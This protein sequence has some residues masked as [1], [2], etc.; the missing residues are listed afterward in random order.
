VYGVGGEFLL[1]VKVDGVTYPVGEGRLAHLRIHE[2]SSVV[3]PMAEVA[4]N[5]R[6]N[7]LVEIQG[8]TGTEVFEIG[9]GDREDNI[10]YYPY[11]LFSAVSTRYGSDSH[12]VKLLLVAEKAVPML[13]PARFKS[14]PGSTVANVVKSIAADLDLTVETEA[15]LGEFDLF[16]P[17]W[18]YAQF[19]AWLADRARSKAHGTSGFLYFVDLDNKLHFYSAEYAKVR[20]AQV[21]VIRKDLADPDSYD[22]KDVD[23]GPY[24]VYQNPMLM[25]NQAAWGLTSAF[26]DF[27]SNKFVEAPLTVDGSQGAPRSLG[28]PGFASFERGA[29]RGTTVKGL[30]D[31][32]SMLSS[33]TDGRN[34]IVNG[35]VQNSVPN[36]TLEKTYN[37]ARLVRALNSMSKQ[38]LLL[39][40]DLRVRAGGLINQ[41]I[42][43]PLPQNVVNQTFSGKW[44]V[45][46]VTHQLVPQFVTKVT[47]FRAGISGSDKAGLMVPPGGVVGKK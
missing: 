16:C 37:E 9:I 22:E 14:Y 46:K 5:D 30:A 41:Q 10:T 11:R 17:G 13:S 38:E 28:A 1:D 7:F 8:L 23:L 31:S 19:L 32:L 21:N 24:R 26:F 47:V 45:E 36:V 40:G 33:H 42:G 2:W 39:V 44:V 12:L 27:E 20:S 4:L 25:G 6:T 3:A 29:T 34:V 35:G 43:S 15:T 18:T